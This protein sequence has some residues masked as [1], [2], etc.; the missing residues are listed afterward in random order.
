[1]RIF[2]ENPQVDSLHQFCNSNNNLSN[3]KG[4]HCNDSIFYLISKINF[5]SRVDSKLG[6]EIQDQTSALNAARSKCFEFDNMQT[7]EINYDISA[8]F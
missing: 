5:V 2:K 1:M 8:S 7:N 3:E 6:D 4:H